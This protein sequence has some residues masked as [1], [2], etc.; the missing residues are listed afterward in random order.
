MKGKRLG[1]RHRQC[2]HL[3]AEAGIDTLDLLL[4]QTA[5]M[6]RITHGT[7]GADAD[8][9]MAVI[10]TGTDEIKAAG[11][12]PLGFE[13]A[14]NLGDQST[15][16]RRNRLGGGDRLGKDTARG[17][18]ARRPLRLDCFG[19]PPRCLVETA[20]QH[21]AETCQQGCPRCFQQRADAL[22]TKPAQPIQGLGLQPQPGDRQ[23]C[24]RRDRVTCGRDRDR[25][26]AIA[27]E[28]MGCPRRIGNRQ[29]RRHARAGKTLGEIVQQ[30]GLTT[31]EMIT[32]RN[33]EPQPIGRIGGGDRGIA[34]HTPGREIAQPRQIGQGF[35][36]HHDKVG[37]PC[38][39]LG[40]GQ[41]GHE[42]QTPGVAIDRGD[43]TARPVADDR[44]QRPLNRRRGTAHPPP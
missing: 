10:D 11:T 17:D 16:H 32:A 25:L 8:C 35:S 34:P 31:V 9:L 41:A 19:D 37:H 29:P 13:I 15:Q 27:G 24:Q 12:L 40:Q 33:V 21:R 36:R 1:Q 20:A 14:A 30:L 26:A 38:G 23:R 2:H 7:G 3:D 39:R 28:R 4:H 18:H 42:A 22:K 43:D 6:R 44:Y 5:E